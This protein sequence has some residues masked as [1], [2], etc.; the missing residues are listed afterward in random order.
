[1]QNQLGRAL[2]ESF[3][4]VS[5]PSVDALSRE[6]RAQSVAD[7]GVVQLFRFHE[8]HRE[9]L[10]IPSERFLVRTSVEYANPQLTLEELQGIVLAR[11]LEV[12]AAYLSERSREP[13]GPSDFEAMAQLLAEP[14]QGPVLPFLM[15]VDDV[16]ADRYSI[17]PLRGSLVK[18]AQTAK[19]AANVVIDGL[20]VDRAFVDKYRGS[21]IGDRDVREIEEYLGSASNSSYA[22]FVDSVK[23]GQLDRLSAELGLQ[24][25]IPAL[26]MPITTLRAET[27]TGRVHRLVSA[28]HSDLRMLRKVYS[29]FGRDFARRKT[30]LPAVPHSPGGAASKRLVRGHIQVNETSI[31]RIEARY[32]SG[33]LYPN[34]IDRGDVAQAY[35]DE[36]FEV[37]PSKFREYDFRDTPASPQFALYMVA[38]PENGAIWH[39]AGKYA[40]MQIVESYTAFHRETGPARS[41]FGIPM[42]CPP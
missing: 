34:E 38:S 8:G 42:D 17:N 19:A 14:P 27:R 29:L 13:L 33:P 25:S 18:T 40:G 4:D 1:M 22:D 15:N 21:L 16:E 35:A 41:L 20:E 3:L 28:A 26:R 9:N 30:L 10:G 11:L 6:L 32:G 2:L 36:F 24:L 39:G 12:A 37:P 5:R 31:E 7:R 23:Y